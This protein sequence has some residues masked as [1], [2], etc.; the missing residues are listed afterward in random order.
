MVQGK[1]CASIRSS[2]TGLD[3]GTDTGG[4]ETDHSSYMQPET[5]NATPTLTDPL[6]TTI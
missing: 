5:D 3:T 2:L 4:N 1:N 6:T